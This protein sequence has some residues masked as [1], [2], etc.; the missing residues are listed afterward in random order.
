M[1]GARLT[2]NQQQSATMMQFRFQP[3]GFIGDD[4]PVRLEFSEGDNRAGAIQVGLSRNRLYYEIQAHT[5]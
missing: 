2:A 1:S 5:L 3:D 4:C